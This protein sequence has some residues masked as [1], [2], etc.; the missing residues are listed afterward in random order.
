MCE[1]LPHGLASYA[2]Q[3][4][5]Q[6]LVFAL[7]GMATRSPRAQAR[8]R[9]RPALRTSR[10]RTPANRT[11]T[12]S[13]R[14]AARTL[15]APGSD[16]RQRSRLHRRLGRDARADRVAAG[17]HEVALAEIVDLVGVPR[18]LRVDRQPPI[19]FFDDAGATI[20]HEH[21]ISV[22]AGAEA[23]TSDALAK[24]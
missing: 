8:A 6:Y 10:A 14:L 18:A 11:A 24:R 21:R 23:L 3:V 7:G 15:G 2:A 13:R 19:A 9:T 16:A 5:H 17:E 1:T 22:E 20:E 4:R 12:R